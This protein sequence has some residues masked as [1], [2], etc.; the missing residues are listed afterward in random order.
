MEY[1]ALD[2]K[3]NPV[4]ECAYIRL[5]LQQQGM[6]YKTAERALEVYDLYRRLSDDHERPLLIEYGF[7]NIVTDM[8]S[9]QPI[10]EQWRDHEN[11]LFDVKARAL[12]RSRYHILAKVLSLRQENKQQDEDLYLHPEQQ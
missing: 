2:L 8:Y 7:E 6:P 10:G 5:L 3:N 9:R 12:S 4:A 1:E 11:D